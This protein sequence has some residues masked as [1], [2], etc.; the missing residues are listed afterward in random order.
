VR[1]VAP[2]YRL[3]PEHAFAA[4]VDDAVAAYRGLIAAGADPAHVAVGG[5]SAGGGLA[6]ALLIALRDAGDP[7]PACATLLSPWTDLEL[8]GATMTTRAGVDPMIS[9]EG[10]RHAAERYL[11]GANPRDPLASPLYGDLAGMPPLLIQVGDAEVLLDDSVRVAERARAVGV[12]V[13]IDVWP[14]M[15]HVWQFFTGQVPEADEAI[16]KLGAFITEHIGG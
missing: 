2:D 1:I 7:L 11:Q 5:D 8:S 6:L 9:P 15:I 10:A 4:A 13:T 14:E 12:D 3:A 16:G